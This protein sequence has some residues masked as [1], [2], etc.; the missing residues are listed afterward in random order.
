MCKNSKA[1][2][3]IKYNTKSIWRTKTVNSKYQ[4]ISLILH[5]QKLQSWPRYQYNTIPNSR[6]SLKT[7]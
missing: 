5:V 2:P 1:K 6:S 3:D 7:Q 4:S